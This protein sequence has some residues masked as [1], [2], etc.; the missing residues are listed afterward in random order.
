VLAF[1]GLGY[2]DHDIQ[3]LSPR[4]EPMKDSGQ[5]IP[6]AKLGNR[7]QAIQH[8]AIPYIHPRHEPILG[9]NISLPYPLTRAAYGKACGNILYSFPCIEFLNKYGI[10]KDLI[11]RILNLFV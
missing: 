7:T 11:V 5:I 2:A 8:L 3:I 6:S 1:Y 4:S 10:A 9:V